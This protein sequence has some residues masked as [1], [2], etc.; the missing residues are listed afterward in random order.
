MAQ[1]TSIGRNDFGAPLQQGIYRCM[2][3][4]ITYVSKQLGK[5]LL[6]RTRTVF[7]TPEDDVKVVCVVSRKYED[8]KQGNYWFAF[9]PHQREELEK[10]S[11]SYAAFGCGTPEYVFLIPGHAFVPWLD[12]MNTTEKEGRMYWHVQIFDQDGK[13]WLVR[14]K[15][16]AKIDLSEYLVAPT[17]E[18]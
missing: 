14:K 8:A 16:E 17:I 11:S 18:S 13:I 6:K 5:T 2:D 3:A 4:C 9:H 7:S 12:G 15:G 10:T 1:G